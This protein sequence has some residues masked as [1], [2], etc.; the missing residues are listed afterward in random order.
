MPKKMLVR[1]FLFLSIFVFWGCSPKYKVVYDYT[2]PK[3]STSRHL[4]QK[5]Y[6]D[7]KLCNKNC[8][9]VKNDCYQKAINIAKDEYAKKMS[10]YKDKLNSYQMEYKNYLVQKEQKNDLIEKITY[11]TDVCDNKK[12]KYACQKGL[13]Y[14]YQL[15]KL[16][17]L[18]KP[19]P[20]REP[21]LDHIIYEKK[22][23]VCGD[24]CPCQEQFRSCYISNGGIVTPRKI[25]I[26][27]CPDD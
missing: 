25:C 23:S 10:V 20:P 15:K 2:P 13:E 27:N 19:I 16:K 22:S 5:C 9:I 4:I 14:Q 11:Y 17:Y 3:D 26:A 18:R 24:S 6:H 8:D 1:F 21:S 7:L 12:D